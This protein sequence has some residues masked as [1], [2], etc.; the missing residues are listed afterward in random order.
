MRLLYWT[1]ARIVN[2]YHGARPIHEQLLAGLVLLP[3]HDM[4]LAAPALVQFAESGVAIAVRVGSPVLLSQQ[5]LGP[6]WMLL[7]LAVK[8]REVRHWQ[9]GRAAARWPPNNAASSRS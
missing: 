4:L 8:L 6:V 2:R 5:L 7:T 9:H 1:T 3:Q